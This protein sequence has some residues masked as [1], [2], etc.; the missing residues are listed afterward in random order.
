MF[1]RSLVTEDFN[2]ERRAGLHEQRVVCGSLR[3]HFLAKVWV[4]NVALFKLGQVLGKISGINSN[5]GVHMLVH[6][7]EVANLIS[8]LLLSPGE[9]MLTIW[10]VCTVY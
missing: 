8:N 9:W 7:L 5:V 3:L 4:R 6:L 10:M 2:K 1:L